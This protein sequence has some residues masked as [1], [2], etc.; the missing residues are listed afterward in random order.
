MTNGRVPT[1]QVEGTVEAT[2]AKGLKIAG[3]WVN[4][5]QFRPV[6]L[7]DVGAHV[8]VDV[9]SKGFIKALEVLDAHPHL[10]KTGGVDDRITRLAVLKAA[11]NFVGLM[12]Q[13]REDVRSEHVLPLADKWLAWISGQ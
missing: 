13:S 12:G 10:S 1:E 6:E 5:S 3:A 7:P 9:D 11:A 2:N 8:R 4:V